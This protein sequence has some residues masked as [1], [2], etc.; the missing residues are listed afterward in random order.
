MRK[1]GLSLPGH[2]VPQ[3]LTARHAAPQPSSSLREF[4]NHITTP[5]GRPSLK[6]N[7][8]RTNN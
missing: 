2:V 4:L 7:P 8:N 6:A 1:I 3:I 5:K